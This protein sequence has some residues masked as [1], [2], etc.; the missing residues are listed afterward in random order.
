MCIITVACLKIFGLVC[1]YTYVSPININIDI[2]SYLIRS[3]WFDCQME[4]HRSAI[5]EIKY[6]EK[7]VI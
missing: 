4:E 6:N 1:K 2:T 3:V 5:N 7:Q